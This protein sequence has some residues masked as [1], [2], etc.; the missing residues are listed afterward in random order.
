VLVNTLIGLALR[1]T[2]LEVQVRLKA[3]PQSGDQNHVHHH[4]GFDNLDG[5]VGENRSV[6]PAVAGLESQSGGLISRFSKEPTRKNSTT[7]HAL[8]YDSSY[9]DPAQNNGRKLK[10]I[11]RGMMSTRALQLTTD[12]CI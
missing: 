4:F 10:G 5:K 6:V 1:K 9:N 2:K 7:Y 11:H 3:L 12:F 8:P